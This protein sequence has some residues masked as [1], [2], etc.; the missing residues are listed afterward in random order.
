MM[1]RDGHVVERP[2]HELTDAE[3]YAVRQQLADHG[4]PVAFG[5]DIDAVL[6]VWA[7]A[8]TSTADEVY[9]L[10]QVKALTDARVDWHGV[11]VCPIHGT[12]T[13]TQGCSFCARTG[14]EVAR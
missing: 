9:A 6:H 11:P 4:I 1:I 10:R 14:R 7:L 8:P 13:P 3:A 12:G 5:R 2:A